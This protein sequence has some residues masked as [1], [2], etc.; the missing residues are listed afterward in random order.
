MVDWIVPLTDAAVAGLLLLIGGNLGSFLNVVAHRLPLGKS[1]VHGGSRC[2]D[3]GA[4]IRWHDNVPVLGWLLLGG[5][6]RD[7]RRP[8]AARYPLVEAAAAVVIGGVAAAELLGGGGTVPGGALGP[9]RPGADNLLLRPDWRLVAYALFHAWLLFNLLLVATVEADGRRVPRRWLVATIL[10][11]L[12]AV[13]LADWLVPVDAWP[14]GAPAGADAPRTVL[15][16]GLVIGLAGLA[17]GALLG[18]WGPP[19]WRA[20]A[21]LVGAALGW[22]ALVGVAVLAPACRLVRRIIGSL[23][24]PV[25]APSPD[26]HAPAVDDPPG[27]TVEAIPV[28]A[29][30]ARVPM[31][32]RLHDGAMSWFDEAEGT[33]GDVLVA[34]AIHLVAWRWW[35][36]LGW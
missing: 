32:T 10:L 22:Q 2:P 7:C 25:P 9:G 29:E 35:V 14:T 11:G 27:A 12:A 6:C 20:Q 19:A 5:R 28:A 26:E 36:G 31:A 8:I 15:P 18:A 17:C 23:L 24:P 33:G 16:R 21:L 34:T 3:C 13:S 4:A 1:V 30:P